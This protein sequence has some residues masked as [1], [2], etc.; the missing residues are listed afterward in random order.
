MS[1]CRFCLPILALFLLFM[2]PVTY[3]GTI[4]IEIGR[5]D[6]SRDW[7]I[8][9]ITTNLK[10]VLSITSKDVEPGKEEKEA[11]LDITWS[12]KVDGNNQNGL[13]IS[14]GE[15]DETVT[16]IP[17]SSA[18]GEYKGTVTCDVL[19][20]FVD[21]E[22]GKIS[23][24]GKDSKT[25]EVVIIIYKI[26]GIA[27]ADTVKLGSQ[28]TYSVTMLPDDDKASYNYVG[29][30]NEDLNYFAAA[31]PESV[32]K[33]VYKAVAISKKL[34]RS[35]DTI[36]CQ[37]WDDDSNTQTLT[38]KIEVKDPSFTLS[39]GVRGRYYDVINGDT[40]Y[41][42]QNAIVSFVASRVGGKEWEDDFPIWGGAAA[43]TPNHSSNATVQFEEVSQ[44]END[45]K[46]VSVTGG[47]DSEDTISVNIVT[48]GFLGVEVSPGYGS[49][50]WSSSAT[51][52]VGGIENSAVHRAKI[53]L[54]FTCPLPEGTPFPAGITYSSNDEAINGSSAKEVAAKITLDNGTTITGGTKTR[55]EITPNSIDS[56]G[57][58]YG[59]VISSD[60]V[61]NVGLNFKSW[62]DDNFSA[63]L[64][65]NWGD[66][67][68]KHWN[69]QKVFSYDVAEDVSLTLL[70]N[71][72]VP[73]HK[74]EL[75]FKATEI[76]F[77]RL[78]T[79]TWQFNKH[80]AVTDENLIPSYCYLSTKGILGFDKDGNKEKV[81]GKATTNNL[82]QATT[83][84][85]VIGSP[86]GDW[87][88]CVTH[89]KFAAYDNNAY[90]K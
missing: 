76:E 77:V 26:S 4:S 90:S 20:T 21:E 45:T 60:A 75:E 65:F 15:K 80:P 40:I 86:F 30:C 16:I 68:D 62:T 50:S 3:A 36:Y 17:M 7:G 10:A 27:G 78:D 85:V 64:S 88:Y 12:I 9:G 63:S 82:G 79:T 11:S 43:G 35:I 72:E 74:H 2:I 57:Y 34:N 29:W 89:V 18:A 70:L 83:K 51:I 31:E 37:F 87:T 44:N 25:Y 24:Y 6:S 22:T 69:H 47:Y 8:S 84:Q 71:G 42:P 33:Q 58:L 54:K 38:K 81:N 39:Y 23:S 13:K 48:V 61:G 52:A 55:F 53:R 32:L 73:I 28:E 41:V 1:R 67:V 46:T 56:L 19:Q 14:S 59:T 66:N 49:E 5:D